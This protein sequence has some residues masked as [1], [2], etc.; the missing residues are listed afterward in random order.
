[1][2]P[3]SALLPLL[4]L[5]LVSCT[6][7]DDRSLIETSRRVFGPLPD[8]RLESDTPELVKLGEHLYHSNEL[9]VNRTQSCNTCHPVATGGV[10][11]LPTSKGALGTPGRR[12][13]PTV[14]NASMHLAQF[15]DGR[16]ATLEEQAA[17]PIVNPV[18]MAMPNAE[19]VA[20]RLRTSPA[21]DRELFRKAFPGDAQPLTLDHASKAIAAFERTLRT[22]DRFDEFMK[23]DANALTAQEKDGLRRFMALGCTSCHNGPLVGARIYQRIGIVNEWPNPE[24]R[25]R[26]EVTKK[27]ADDQV[28]KVP[29]LRNVANTA[30]YFHDGS[31]DQLD[32]AVQR[33]A[34]HQLGKELSSEDRDA[35][36]AFL[37][38]LTDT[39]RAAK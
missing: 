6:P 28:F 5:A 27:P 7:A 31:V 11:R 35:V 38:A 26:F 3:R 13:T 25:G 2:S 22:E 37:H 34:W 30:P 39:S 8:Q 23:G 15:W 20:E 9:S 32:T 33:M 16:A 17:G 4:L 19:A 24:D 1:M 12:N 29:A 18:E 10:D 21:I 14:F 36:V